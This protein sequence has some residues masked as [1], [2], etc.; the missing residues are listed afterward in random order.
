MFKVTGLISAALKV[1][2]QEIHT[3][4]D[5]GLV[6]RSPYGHLMDVYIYQLLKWF[7]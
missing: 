2:G 4:V 7:S 6:E 1:D 5:P 3:A